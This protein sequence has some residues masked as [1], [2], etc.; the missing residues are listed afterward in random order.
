[1]RERWREEEM[2]GGE[3]RGREG[4]WEGEREVERKRKEGKWRERE[5]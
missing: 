5:G 2:E 3:H 1:M 4:G